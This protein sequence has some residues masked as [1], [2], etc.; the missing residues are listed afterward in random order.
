[1]LLDGLKYW[2]CYQVN[3]T[4]VTVGEGPYV[5]DVETRTSEEGELTILKITTDLFI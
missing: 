2:K 3:V 4:A 1:M 5:A